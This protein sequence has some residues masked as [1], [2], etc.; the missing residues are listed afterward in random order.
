MSKKLN[1]F[2]NIYVEK[3]S[4][5][6]RNTEMKNSEILE[7][8]IKSRYTAQ[9]HSKNAKTNDIILKM[10]FALLS[11]RKI[12]KIHF[13]IRPPSSVDA[14]YKFIIARDRL[15]SKMNDILSFNEEKGSSK[16]TTARLKAI[17]PEQT[18]SSFLKD[19]EEQSY[20]NLK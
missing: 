13:I 7:L 9:S 5:I 19:A 18:K 16:S 15:H 8:N 11:S 1:I 2:L 4:S 20:L 3:H 12:I 17:P 14:G 6:N 10:V